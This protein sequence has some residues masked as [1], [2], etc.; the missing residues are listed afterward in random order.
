MKGFG[1][2]KPFDV[3]QEAARMLVPPSLAFIARLGIF[4]LHPNA[5]VKSQ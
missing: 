5:G 3:F 4:F 1:K 2:L